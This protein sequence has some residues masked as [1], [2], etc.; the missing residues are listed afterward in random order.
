MYSLPDGTS[1]HR[2]AKHMSQLSQPDTYG[3]FDEAVRTSEAA[4]TLR[5]N[6]IVELMK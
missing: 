3:Y 6:Q 2:G 5:N 4:N 1:F